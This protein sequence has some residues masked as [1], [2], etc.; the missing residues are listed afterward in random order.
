MQKRKHDIEILLMSCEKEIQEIQGAYDASLHDQAI[1][2]DLRVKIK[3]FF[4][5][6]R[7]V[8][9]YIAC[10]IC[11]SL[12]GGGDPR[13]RVYFPIFAT[14]E[15]FESNVRQRFPDI[16]SIAQ[17]LW[18][19]LEGI[20]PYHDAYKWLG[21]FGE[22]TNLNKHRNLVPQVRGE[23]EQV[24]VTTPTGSVSWTPGSVRFGS[25]VKIGG[26]PVDPRTQLPVPHPSRRVDRIIWVDFRF[27][28]LDTSALGLAKQ[29][30]SG[31][32]KIAGE[33]E[34]WL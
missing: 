18:D 23:T 28:G 1:S 6:L 17:D 31:I 9:D 4:E 15:N 20:Q 25:G 12:C 34:K 26:V 10:D 7:S 3:N 24:R 30:L 27:E 16:Q 33:I 29:A 5:N 13:V 32:K 2:P 22:I 8:L 21:V 19:Y 14:R 11:D